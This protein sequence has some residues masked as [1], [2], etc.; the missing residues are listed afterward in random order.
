MTGDMRTRELAVF[1]WFFFVMLMLGMTSTLFGVIATVLFDT[2]QGNNLVDGFAAIGMVWFCAGCLGLIASQVIQRGRFVGIMFGCGIIVLVL[3]VIWLVS[4]GWLSRFGDVYR[5]LKYKHMFSYFSLWV[6]C[7]VTVTIVVIVAFILSLKTKSSEIEIGKR[8]MASSLAICTTL[9]YTILWFDEFM[10]FEIL[11]IGLGIGWVAT[12]LGLVGISLAVRREN[13]PRGRLVRTISKRAKMK[14][15]CPQCQ[16][17]LE[18]SSGPVRCD[19]CGLR[20]IVE[21]KEP[22]CACGYLLYELQGNVCPECGREI[23]N[24]ESV[25]THLRSSP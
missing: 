24:H 8:I 13:K 11:V 19:E 2:S 23:E 20:M 12:I 22:R 15:A 17:W 18:V 21:I 7:F 3:S 10:E 4:Y 16:Q 14:M 9:S 1:R 6:F 5:L 25:K